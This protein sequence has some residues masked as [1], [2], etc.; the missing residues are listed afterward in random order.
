MLALILAPFPAIG[1]VERDEALRAI[2]DQAGAIHEWV[3]SAERPAWLYTN[4]QDSARAAGEAL[5]RSQREHLREG[6]PIISACRD[7][8]Q[9]CPS[10]A[11]EVVSAMPVR[12][13]AGRPA[14][15]G[16]DQDPP[17]TTLRAEDI[18]L[19]VLVSR[20]L[21]P[22]QLKEIFA[23]ASDTPRVRVAFRGVAEDES[24]M[25]FVRRIHGLL[26][27]I[28]PVPEVVLD[29]TPFA[30]AGTDI[31]PMILAHG[32]DRELARVAGLA[33]PLWLRA[34]VLA[35]ERGDLGMLG[36]VKSVTEPDLIEDLQRRLAAL[37]LERM[38]EQAIARYWQRVAF[39]EL[40][41]AAEPRTREI[42]STITAPQ[43]LRTADGTLLVRAGETLNPLDRLPFTQRLVVFDA[44]DERQVLTARH[45]GR[46]VGERRVLYLVTQLERSRGWE[47]LASVEDALDAPVY[48]LTPDVRQRF[49]LERVPALVE[50]RG[51]VFVVAEVPPETGR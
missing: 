22:A 32:P 5:G 25:D 15:Q 45:L 31:A 24:L 47:G 26:A 38:R 50:A 19:T 23:F 48:L 44:S 43:D 11:D 41:V 36:P 46:E 33:D 27:G 42:D 6:L 21:G 7:L 35:G 49:A 18:T 40:P 2:R 51:Q 13:P 17:A 37:D 3:E 16:A 30:A 8:G 4:P 12:V 14:G 1:D 34:R 20:S 28:E 10:A 9:L 29:P 39:E